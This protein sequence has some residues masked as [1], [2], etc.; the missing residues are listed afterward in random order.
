MRTVE[1]KRCGKVMI[2]HQEH[3]WY[4][5]PRDKFMHCDGQVTD[6]LPST[7]AAN[8]PH[9]SPTVFPPGSEKCQ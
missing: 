8:S 2:R 1:N 3:H 6:D 7:I 5:G 9:T 4:D